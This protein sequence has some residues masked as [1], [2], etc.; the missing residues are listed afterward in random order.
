LFDVI[1]SYK[2]MSL[3]PEQQ[4]IRA[5]NYAVLYFLLSDA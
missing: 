3:H 4:A 1:K 2:K 5:F